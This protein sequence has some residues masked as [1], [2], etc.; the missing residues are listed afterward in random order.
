M[1]SVHIL[2]TPYIEIGWSIGTFSLVGYIPLS[3]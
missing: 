3:P 1:F 2:V